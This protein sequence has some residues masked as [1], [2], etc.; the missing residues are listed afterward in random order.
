MEDLNGMRYFWTAEKFQ[1]SNYSINGKISLI[2]LAITL[3]V[4]IIYGH[5]IE[6]FVSQSFKTFEFIR[7]KFSKLFDFISEACPSFYIQQHLLSIS[8]GRLHK[9]TFQLPLR[10]LNIFL[11]RWL[12]YLYQRYSFSHGKRFF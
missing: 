9:N 10:T 7:L 3:K 8:S 12:A 2:E 6:K 1:G 5:K 11:K 4:V